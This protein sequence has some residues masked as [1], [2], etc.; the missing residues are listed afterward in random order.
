MKDPNHNHRNRN[1]PKLETNWARAEGLHWAQKTS[2]RMAISVSSPQAN[3][4]IERDVVVNPPLTPAQP[5]QQP[6]RQARDSTACRSKT[7]TQF[8][9][10][11]RS[12]D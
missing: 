9:T 3:W 6:T 4:L 1:V 12:S 5:W 10:V 7:H 2:F 11:P 8:R